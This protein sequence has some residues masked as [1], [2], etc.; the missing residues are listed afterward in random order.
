VKMRREL[1]E[2]C[3]PIELA[4]RGD[5]AV[6]DHLPIHIRRIEH[7]CA[8]DRL[9]VRIEIPAVHD[10]AQPI[11]FDEHPALRMRRG[12]RGYSGCDRLE[13]LVRRGRP[14]RRIDGVPS[15]KAE[16][17]RHTPFRERSR[18]EVP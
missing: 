5:P 3:V 9:K 14:M 4:L 7:T 17:V 11:A 2:L 10:D 8:L 13:E 1:I 16:R 15:D 6:L 18:V 12:Y